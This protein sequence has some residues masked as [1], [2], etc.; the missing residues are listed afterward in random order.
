M[1]TC[2]LLRFVLQAITMIKYKVVYIYIVYIINPAFISKNIK[3]LTP[4]LGDKI[5]TV[6]NLQTLH[7]YIFYMFHHFATKLSLLIL[8]CSYLPAVVMD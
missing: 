4:Y 2:Q 6:Q 8:R 1:K 5:N 7:G 3:G